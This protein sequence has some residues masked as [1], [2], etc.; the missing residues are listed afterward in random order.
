MFG[1]FKMT[2]WTPFQV[3]YNHETGKK[4]RKQRKNSVRIINE[5]L[6]GNFPSVL[7][8]KFD[9]NLCH[10]HGCENYQEFI[11]ET[12][13]QMACPKKRGN[14]NNIILNSEHLGVVLVWKIFHFP[15]KGTAKLTQKQSILFELA[16]TIHC[17]WQYV[18]NSFSSYHLINNN[19]PYG[20]HITWL[21]VWSSVW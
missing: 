1:Q 17:K 19:Q 21:Y 13:R 12:R 6:I 18:Y 2:S 11:F 10:L 8:K 4:V 16:W 3:I 7:R 14:I 15:L 20:L 5:Q 9:A